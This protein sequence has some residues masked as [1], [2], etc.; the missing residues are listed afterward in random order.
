VISESRDLAGIQV[1]A[2][3]NILPT[4]VNPLSGLL[5]YGKD[6]GAVFLSPKHQFESVP[7]TLHFAPVIAATTGART[8]PNY[9]QK[10]AGLKAA[11]HHVIGGIPDRS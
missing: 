5:I 4:A 11:F 3:A 9:V 10:K 2:E 6:H 7:R 1:C 8:A